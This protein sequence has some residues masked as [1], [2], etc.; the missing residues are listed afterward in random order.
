V[1][2][3]RYSNPSLSEGLGQVIVRGIL[4]ESNEVLRV[5]HIIHGL[6]AS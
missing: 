5:N 3:H 4:P 6:N 1:Y 2:I